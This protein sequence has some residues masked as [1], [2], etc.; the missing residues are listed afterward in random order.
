[1]FQ[2]RHFGG[3]LVAPQLCD[4]IHK[5]IGEWIHQGTRGNL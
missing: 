5:E 3:L 4:D 2:K 1:M